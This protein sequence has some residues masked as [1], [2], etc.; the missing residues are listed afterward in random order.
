[1]SSERLPGKRVTRDDV[2]ELAGVSASTVSY[3]VNNGPRPV[4][5]AARAR[6]LEAIAELGYHPSDIARSLRTQRT[7]TL[8]LVIPNI[9]NPFYAELA[10]GVEEVGF[11]Q[12]YTVILC[13]SGHLLARELR[14][15]QVLRSKGVDGAIFLP[16][17]ADLG[18]LA[19]LREA[20]IRL[21]VLE[22]SVPGYHCLVADERH[23]GYLATRHLLD[24]GHQRI[25]C[26]VR[27]GD[28]TSSA[29]RVEGYRAALAERG[30]PLDDRL[31]VRSEFGYAAGE[32]AARELLA[33]SPRP[34]ALVTHNDIIAIG[35]I[36]AIADAGLSVP[37]QIALVGYDDIAQAAYAQPPLTTIAYPKREMGRLAAERLLSMLADG[38]PISPAT[39]VLPVYLVERGSTAPPGQ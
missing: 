16:T 8:G 6:V 38:E 22:R 12:G 9:A 14:Y 11:E 4:S 23:G 26:I 13:H 17:T 31:I 30:L 39:T 34:T 35:A 5:A 20:R 18:A 33:L 10:R 7:L 37:D 28:L 29:A 15:A 27:A 36:K 24:L 32:R 2:A 19:I 25:G 1:M 21:I 3:V